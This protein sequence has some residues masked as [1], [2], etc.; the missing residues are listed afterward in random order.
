MNKALARLSKS[1]SSIVSILEEYDGFL[2]Q[3]EQ[4]FD[5]D[6]KKLELLCRDHAKNVV[7]YKKKLNELKTIEEFFKIK[8]DEI[9]STH[10]KKYNEKHSRALSTKDIQQYISG[11]PDY[12][13][14]WELI[15]EIVDMKKQYEA[16]VE[17]L[18]EM[19][20]ML[21]HIT[22]LRVAELEE[23]LL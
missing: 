14:Q 20:W 22:K 3:S 15:L 1:P 19:S 9:S 10:W 5:L 13:A 7:F 16:V 2:A 11:E 21:S 17:A 23:A 8:A 4:I 12:V 6:G 18:G